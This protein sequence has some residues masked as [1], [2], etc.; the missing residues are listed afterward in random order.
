[1]FIKIMEEEDKMDEFELSLLTKEE[2]YN[3]PK[4]NMLMK[5]LRMFRN[6]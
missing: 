3:H 6:S 2:A 5:A 1:M 4:K